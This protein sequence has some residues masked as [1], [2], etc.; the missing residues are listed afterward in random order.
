MRIA[1]E[2]VDYDREIKKLW[3]RVGPPAKP[4]ASTSG[5]S[6]SMTT[7]ANSARSSSK[8]MPPLILPG[9]ETTESERCS[10]ST[11]SADPKPAVFKP[12]TLAQAPV[13]RPKSSELKPGDSL[14]YF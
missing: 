7:I 13:S 9:S 12:P 2:W 5:S 8:R 1:P 14:I 3:Q 10:S 11:C 6:P 4:K